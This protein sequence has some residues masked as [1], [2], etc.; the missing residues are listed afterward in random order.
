MNN[1]LNEEDIRIFCDYALG[2]TPLSLSKKYHK[3]KASILEK[4]KNVKTCFSQEERNLLIENMKKQEA[5]KSKESSREETSKKVF[6]L[7]NLNMPIVDICKKMNISQPTMYQMLYKQ[8]GGKEEFNEKYSRSKTK[9]K[10]SF[11]NNAANE[12][13]L[14]ASEVK[15]L[16]PDAPEEKDDEVSKIEINFG[17]GPVQIGN[18]KTI[19][20]APIY[21]N[22][23]N[24]RHYTGNGIAV[25]DNIEDEQVND[26]KY[27]DSMVEKF[28]NEHVDFSASGKSKN[29]LIVYLTGL[30]SALISLVNVCYKRG[31]PIEAMHYNTSD[32]NYV[33]QTILPGFIDESVDA[34][35]W[36]TILESRA[37]NLW[38]CDCDPNKIEIERDD[39]YAIVVQKSRNNNS[40]DYSSYIITDSIDKM[41]AIY[42]KIVAHILSIKPSDA[43]FIVFAKPIFYNRSIES[44]TLACGGNLA[45]SYNF[46]G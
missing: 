6:E 30:Q 16:E 25:F 11:N 3:K 10:I 40:M 12:I 9:K 2:T 42:G 33:N 36:K 31:V 14:I 39:L 19:G 41:W 7:Y 27:L 21:C 46:V 4:I 8:A 13:N 24:D 23:V 38:F 18:I 29:K 43:K 26:F 45:K 34:G 35:P 5:E 28:I 17:F 20:L 32:K 1:V 22:L 37:K 44:Y 15:K